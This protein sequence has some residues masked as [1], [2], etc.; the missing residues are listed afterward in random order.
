MERPPLVDVVLMVKRA[1]C[2]FEARGVIRVVSSILTEH[3][4]GSPKRQ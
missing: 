3:I 2:V 1:P 4:A